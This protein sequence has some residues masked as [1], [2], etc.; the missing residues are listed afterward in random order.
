MDPNNSAAYYYSGLIFRSR[1][2]LAKANEFTNKA[3]SL[4]YKP[5]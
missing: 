2:D 3:L 4:G 5:N 1:G